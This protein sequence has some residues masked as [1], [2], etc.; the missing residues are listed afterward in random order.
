MDLSALGLV[1][2]GF[3]GGLILLSFIRWLFTVFS[4]VGIDRQALTVE[5]FFDRWVIEMA[6]IVDMRAVGPGGV[7][8]RFYLP[9]LG[10]TF[11]PHGLVVR[12]R[13]RRVFGFRSFIIQTP[14]ADLALR[15]WRETAR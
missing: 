5:V 2:L 14:D 12:T 3:V 15:I 11:V 13:S 4:H 9:T 7:L 10:V 1:A 8:A 6:D